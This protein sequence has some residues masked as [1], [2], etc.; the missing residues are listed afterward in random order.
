MEK[1][2][3]SEKGGFE[4]DFSIAETAYVLAQD[5]KVNSAISVSSATPLCIK[6]AAGDSPLRSILEE[7]TFQALNDGPWIKRQRLNVCDDGPTEDN[8]FLSLTFP[9]KLWKIVES[10][11]FKSIW[12]DHGGNCVVIDE[13]LFK[14]E[15]LERRGPLRIFETDCMKSFIRQ[16]N[17]YGFSKMRQDFQRSASLAEFLAEEKAAS[18]LSKVKYE[19]S[20][21]KPQ[22]SLASKIIKWVLHVKIKGFVLS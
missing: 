2:S 7:N 3:L 5:E 4:M 16:L 18:A 1:S 17:L 14:K 20:L 10:D 8:D 15:V 9:N 19:Y 22:M 13:E 11:Q 6:T 21:S 12:W